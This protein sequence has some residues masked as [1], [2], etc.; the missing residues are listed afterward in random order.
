MKCTWSGGGILE[1]D[2]HHCDH[3][4]NYHIL[5]NAPDK[6]IHKN[7]TLKKGDKQVLAQENIGSVS[8]NVKE[9]KRQGNIVT[10]TVSVCPFLD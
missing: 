1:I 8:L 6:G 3:P 10:T 2:L 5:L 4:V 9:L 7:L